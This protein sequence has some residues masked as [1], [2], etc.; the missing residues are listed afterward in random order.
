MTIKSI[1][2][3]NIYSFGDG[4]TPELK[5]FTQFNLFIGKNG[6]GKTNV[7]RALCELEI[8]LKHDRAQNIFIPKLGFNMLRWSYTKNPGSPDGNFFEDRDLSIEHDCGPIIEFKDGSHLSGDFTLY[9]GTYIKHDSSH[10]A[11]NKKLKLLQSNIKL[12]SAME[13]SVKYIFGVDIGLSPPIC[14]KFTKNK[15]ENKGTQG[16]S[17]LLNQWSSGYFSVIGL[18]LSV[19]EGNRVICIDEPELHLEPR[20]LRKLIDV[21]E[22]MCKRDG[23]VEH[24]WEAWLENSTVKN[25]D[26]WEDDKNY[27]PLSNKQIFIASHSPILIN[28]FLSRE[29]FSIYEFDKEYQDSS[30]EAHYGPETRNVEH[31]SLVSVVRKVPINYPHSVLDNLGARGSDLLQCN[32]VIWGEGPSDIIYIRKWLDMHA[33]ENKKTRL[34]Q[35]TDYEFQMYG[36]TL[37]DSLC[38]IKESLD[39]ELEYKKLVSM[40]SF[41]RNAFVI[42]DSDAVKN[43]DG[44]IEDKSNFKAAKKF[45]ASQFDA[46]IKNGYKLGLWYKENNTEIRTLEDYLDEETFNSVGIKMGSTTKKLFAQRVI[47]S[48]DEDKKLEGLN[49]GLEKEIEILDGTIRSWIE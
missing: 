23:D 22:W 24:E 44:E 1:N 15:D 34:K 32:G 28:E 8:D 39:E 18:L 4:G 6:S 5:G 25:S 48:W 31:D 41:S 45:I 14:E 12:R 38:L 36:G 3:R 49:H 47:D 7:F 11:L 40:F 2:L 27:R 10:D 16:R 17:I 13:F 43:A 37:L 26:N 35:G 30:Y 29:N 21:L 46:L 9:K 20:V 42:T 33:D 19:C